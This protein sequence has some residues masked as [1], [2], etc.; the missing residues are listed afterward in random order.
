MSD[1]PDYKKEI[2][3]SG[4]TQKEWY[5][6]IYLHSA[7][8]K[9]L[10]RNALEVHGSKCHGCSTKKRLDVH[11]LQYR[12]IYDVTVADLQ[13]LCRKC[14]SKEHPDIKSAPSPKKQTHCK[15]RWGN[16]PKFVKLMLDK[17]IVDGPPGG[18]RAR[19][20]WAIKRVLKGL[21]ST[22]Q[23]TEELKNALL[24]FKTGKK[25]NAL[26]KAMRKPRRSK[27]TPK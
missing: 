2:A 21:A 20:N 19:K 5:R 11:H 6:N 7:H 1:L 15:A 13:V 9:T 16:L 8:W 14:H 25:A 17:A 27:A 24:V 23:L 3:A 26:R 18:R 12:A 4:L 22:G 10:R